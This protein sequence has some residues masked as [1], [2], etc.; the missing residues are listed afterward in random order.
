VRATFFVTRYHGFTAAKRALLRD[1]A[2]RGHD[3]ETHGV[4]HLRAPEYAEQFGLARYIADE[5]E[6]GAAALRADG[7]DPVAFAY[8]FGARTGELDRALLERFGVVRS[9]TFQRDG[10]LVTDPCPE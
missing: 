9:V 5:V 4:D 8:P 6:P 3:I 7:H 10:L 1:L 2:E